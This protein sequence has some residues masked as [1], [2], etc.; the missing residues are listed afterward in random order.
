[1]AYEG[2]KAARREIK[3]ITDSLVVRQSD[4]DGALSALEDGG[5]EST[6]CHLRSIAEYAPLVNR[7]V[8]EHSAQLL[9]SLIQILGG[10]WKYIYM[11]TQEDRE[12]AVLAEGALKF[13]Q[14]AIAKAKG[15][16][17]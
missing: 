6:A 15:G 4:I 13:A 7:N 3:M 14:A 2:R 5:I 9:S 8:A 16:S 10:Y 11:G 1:M 12:C 17:R